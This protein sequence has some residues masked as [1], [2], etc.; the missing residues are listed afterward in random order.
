MREGVFA[1]ST[2]MTILD[3]VFLQY[4]FQYQYLLGVFY[5]KPVQV[6]RAILRYHGRYIQYHDIEISRYILF[7]VRLLSGS[8]CKSDNCQ[9]QIF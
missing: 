3:K 6:L 9:S 2:T 5:N 8:F 1:I 4:Q 7:R